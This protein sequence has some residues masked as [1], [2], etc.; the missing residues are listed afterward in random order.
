MLS[1]CRTSRFKKDFKK[2]SSRQKIKLREVIEKL[3]NEEPLD[4]Q[5]KNH[6]LEG[7]YVRCRECH[8]ET[9]LLLVY[10]LTE[11][12]LIFDRVANHSNLFG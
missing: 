11:N 4:P 7:N 6:K 1:P 2:L 3:A 10:K 9:D 12:E 8:I 5:L